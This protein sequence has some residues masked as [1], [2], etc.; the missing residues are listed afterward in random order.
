[1]AVITISRQHGS[2]GH[3]VTRLLC[4]QLDYRFFDKDLM[5]HL[6]AQLGLAPDQVIDLPEDRHQVQS[7]V[8]RLFANAPTPFGDPGEWALQAKLEAQQEVSVQTFQSLIRAAHEQGK[9]VVMGRG[10]QA[11]L[12]DAPDVLHVRLVAPIELRIQRVQQNAGVSADLARERVS[13]RDRASAEYVKRFYNVDVDDPLLYDLVI[14]TSKLTAA[15]TA[16]LI[17]KT[18]GYLPA[19][20]RPKPSDVAV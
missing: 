11:V 8:E 13:E 20:A 4:D 19:S 5:A 2:G 18:L 14:N 15:A 10:G 1:M 16:D 9:V 12:R 7:L 3:A 6:G 17:I